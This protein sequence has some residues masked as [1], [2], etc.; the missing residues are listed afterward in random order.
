MR[1][2]SAFFIISI[3]SS[4]L[5]S[6]CE[7]ICPKI[8]SFTVDSVIGGEAKKTPAFV[9]GLLENIGGVSYLRDNLWII[10]VLI[11][12]LAVFMGTFNF[13]A[14]LFNRKGSETLVE[15]MRNRLFTHIEHLPFSWYMKNQ[16][17]DI[18]QRCTSDV[19]TVK[20]FLSDQLTEVIKTILLVVMSLCFMYSVNASVATVAL[21]S[22]PIIVIYSTVFRSLIAHKF[23]ECDENEGKLSSIVQENLTGVRVVRA[24]G[25][26]K[27]EVDKFT[28]QNKLYTGLWVKLCGILSVFW[29]TGDVISGLQ[30]MIVLVLGSVLCVKG[31]MSVGDLI[32]VVSY[33]SMLI[34]PVR[35]L[36]RVISEMS[37][38]GVSVGRINEIIDA[39]EETDVP[40]AINADM[41]GDIVFDHVSFAYENSPKI[42]DDVSLTIKKGSTVGII[43]MTGSG[44]STLVSLLCRLYE[45]P[46]NCG[47]I[48]VSGLDIR[49]IKASSLRKNIGIVLQEPFLFSRTIRENIGITLDDIAEHDQHIMDA[50]ASACI[51]DAIENFSDGYDTM[52]GERGVTLSGGQKQR[53]AIAR[54]LLQN[55]PVMIFDDSLSAVDSE[56]DAK[57]RHALREKTAEATVILISH[58]IQT[59]AYADNIA[60]MN[61]GKIVERGTHE[62]LLKKGGIYK[63]IFDIQ[64]SGMTDESEEKEV[65]A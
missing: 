65:H 59:L 16:T 43:G 47:K 2:C 3:V 64:T 57:I 20:S 31:Q 10:A 44:K 26:E 61:G 29:A 45:L 7:L 48:T 24:F 37:K 1:G 14:I 21:V 27:Y 30:V 46:E 60:V 49:K 22:I 18:I 9:S 5:T 13:S 41:S 12:A 28:K 39:E 32:A 56:T 55:T 42:L 36:G 33:N 17:G 52:V 11:L 15:N 23:L 38:A 58:R 63:N 54:L 62:E 25:R 51:S 4:L 50:A 40:D 34:W 8:I 6:L 35:Q 19:E 53:T